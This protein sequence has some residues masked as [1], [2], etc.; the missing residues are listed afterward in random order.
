MPTYIWGP[1]WVEWRI[2]GGFIAWMPMPPHHFF[3][4]KHHNLYNNYRSNAYYYKSYADND[5]YFS[6][7]V[8]VKAENFFERNISKYRIKDFDP[9]LEFKAIPKAPDKQFLEKY[10][11]FKVKQV[12]L[13]RDNIFIAGKKTEYYTPEGQLESIIDGNKNLKNIVIPF[14]KS[15]LDNSGKKAIVKND[16][17]YFESMGKNS[18]DEN[19]YPRKKPSDYNEYRN[20]MR[21]E[22]FPPKPVYK[23]ENDMAVQGKDVYLQHYREN[24]NGEPENL[25]NRKDGM[26]ETHNNFKKENKNIILKEKRTVENYRRKK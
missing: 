6:G 25:L 20:E 4:K 17:F 24:Y 3:Y 8:V 19:L 7:Y 21:E 26:K 5:Y 9:N 22:K 13:R 15:D 14:R 10:S 1:A 23:Y 16:R 11:N 2:S 18:S 12:N